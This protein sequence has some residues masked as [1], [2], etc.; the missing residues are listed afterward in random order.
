M[1]EQQDPLQEY[2]SDAVTFTIEYKPHCIAEYHVKAS[3]EIVKTAYKQAIKAIAKEV[4]LPGFRKGK[5]PDALIIKNFSGPIEE[6][7]KKTIAD[8]AFL[9][10]QKVAKINVLDRDTR[11]SFDMKKFSAE[12]G[13]EMTYSFEME[14]IVPEINLD[15][16][17]L[18]EVKR[19]TVDDQKVED[20]IHQIQ[21]FF[22]N[23][24]K[25][26]N[27]GVEENDTI[28]IDV[29][30]IETEPAERA[31][32]N[33]RFEVKEEKL[34][35][36]MRDLVL[37]ME[38]GESKEGVSQ[39]DEGASEEE[40]AATPPKK[41]LLTLKGIELPR[42]PEIDDALAQKVGVATAA[43]MRENIQK[44]LNKQADEHVT[45]SY[46]EQVTEFL[47]T[48]YPFPLPQSSVK[49]ET[50]HRI[51][52]LIS[53]PQFQKK[54]TAMTPDERKQTISNLELQAE[55]AIRLFYISR[56]IAEEQ[57]F[58]LLSSEVHKEVTT[59]LE[60]MFSEQ[61]D[62]YDENEPSQEK[63]SLAMA[64]L[65]LTKTEDFLISKAKIE[66]ST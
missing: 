40:K 37:G 51:K 61:T 1:E 24:E 49:G 10:C 33:A 6:R 62:Y 36:W 28:I 58:S 65:L 11:I 18:R 53:D 19:E 9:E 60:A 56:K 30:I 20:M 16:I 26:E 22:A 34:A 27:R 2:K 4:S 29:D 43:Q 38:I 64:R 3:P 13:A 59:P 47:L 8:L 63:K 17:T 66:P 32:T 54:I 57:K 5:T 45:R 41:I 15:N 48:N 55:R 50:Q 25:I 39:V 31:L 52:Q 23:W 35:K 21:M 44:L 14:P 7:W 46:R 42:L 12:E